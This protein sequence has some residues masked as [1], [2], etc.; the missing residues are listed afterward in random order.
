MTNDKDVILI[1]EDEADDLFFIKMAFEEAGITNPIR[2]AEDCE[3][4]IAYLTGKGE[5]A[6]RKRYPMPVLVLLDLRLPDQSGLEVLRKIKE[7]NVRRMS[8]IVFTSSSNVA[9]V[10]AAYEA[11]ATSY[12]VKPLTTADRK[13]FAT[14]VKE[15]WL[16]YNLF[17]P[18]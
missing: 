3:A 11:G 5:F 2:E 7:M 4:A 18:A 6:N 9:D 16:G 10:K 13:H 14:I 15:Y 8:V 17:P 12:V 1:V